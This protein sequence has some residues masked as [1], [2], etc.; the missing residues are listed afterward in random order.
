MARFMEREGLEYRPHGFRATFRTWAEEQTDAEY[1]VKETALGH[2]VGS[3]VER[4]YQR[5]DLIEKRRRLLE[6][7]GA[8]LALQ[9]EVC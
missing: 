2:K 1:E 9:K 3:T 4:A 6:R 5:S 8:F 7:W